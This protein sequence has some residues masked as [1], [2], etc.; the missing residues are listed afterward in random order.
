MK[1]GH[2]PAR[3]SDLF[4]REITVAWSCSHFVTLLAVDERKWME[5]LY[6]VGTS[7]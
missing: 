5:L 2:G 6:S 7:M 4:V 3:G 1:D